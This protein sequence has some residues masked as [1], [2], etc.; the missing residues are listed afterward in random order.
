MHLE[1]DLYAIQI[2]LDESYI[3][4]S[5][6]NKSYDKILNP[7]NLEH[8]N[9]TST[10]S[11]TV[12]EAGNMKKIALI[13]EP[14]SCVSHCGV[15]ENSMLT[16]LQ[17]NTITQI[18]LKTKEIVQY[19]QFE[20][21]GCSIALYQCFDGYII[22]GEVEIIKLNHNFEKKWSFSGADIFVTPDNQPTF[23]MTENRIK[24]YDWNGTYYEL[25]LDG[26]LSTEFH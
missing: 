21:F 20:C 1:N 26:T 19:K 22:H 8:N 13:G 9:L 12:T 16:V 5:P 17:N 2:G 24:L 4:D 7:A 15:L 25:D 11:I 6:D 23:E 3:V 10:F 18:D 14:F